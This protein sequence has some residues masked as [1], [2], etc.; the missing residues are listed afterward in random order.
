MTIM[1]IPYGFKIKKKI[2]TEKFMNEC[3]IAGC[4]YF[5]KITD[6]LAVFFSKHKDGSVSVLEKRWDLYNPFN[7]LLEVANTKNNCYEDTVNDYIWKYRKH[8][9]AAWFNEKE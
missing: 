2:D 7:P 6:D 4:E 3:M 1:S 9:N 8:I 5:L